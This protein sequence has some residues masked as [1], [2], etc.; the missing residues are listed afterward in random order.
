MK[1]RHEFITSTFG[2]VR[3]QMK[4]TTIRQAEKKM[5]ISKNVVIQ[6]KSWC[7]QGNLISSLFTQK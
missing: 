3:C 2:G 4:S 7:L 6:N 5:K 1:A